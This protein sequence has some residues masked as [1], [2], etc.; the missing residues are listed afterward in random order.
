MSEKMRNCDNDLL[1]DLLHNDVLRVTPDA[2]QAAK[3][4]HAV[5]YAY[6]HRHLAT[7]PYNYFPVE[8]VPAWKEYAKHV[9]ILNMNEPAE[10]EY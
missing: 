2:F 3:E 1:N 6:Q 4:A 7:E 8:V 9:K 5:L 10:G